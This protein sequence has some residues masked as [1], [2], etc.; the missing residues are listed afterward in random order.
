MVFVPWTVALEFVVD[1]QQWIFLKVEK[2]EFAE[3]LNIYNKR[4]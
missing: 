3:R 1:G 4:K 2:V